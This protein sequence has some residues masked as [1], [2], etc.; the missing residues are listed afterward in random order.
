MEGWHVAE[1]VC[2]DNN[3]ANGTFWDADMEMCMNCKEGCK[4]CKD[5]S[6]CETCLD[7]VTKC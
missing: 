5:S 7:P 1:D 6:E 4:T 3:C 2:V